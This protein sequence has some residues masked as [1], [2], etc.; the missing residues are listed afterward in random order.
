MNWKT[1]DNIALVVISFV[2]ITW[3]AMASSSVVS[4]LWN[5]SGPA[6]DAFVYPISSHGSISSYAI[7]ADLFGNQIVSA[8]PL[9]ETS[10]KLLLLGVM[11][12]EEKG[13]GLAILHTPSNQE[14][15]YHIGESPMEGVTL[16]AVFDDHVILERAGA[17][18]S[19]HFSQSNETTV[20][21][22]FIAA[23]Q[24]DSNLEAEVLPQN[25]RTD[26]SV[27]FKTV[28][29][30]SLG[31]RQDMLALDSDQVL[32][33]MG[34]S[35]KGNTFQLGAHSPLSQFGLQE[36]DQVI[37]VNGF[38]VETLRSDTALQAELRGSPSIQ[39]IIV[40]GGKRLQINFSLK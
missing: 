29:R 4:K 2:A 22:M 12:S 15:A 24:F 40:R 6:S 21:N 10:L 9:Q 17:S 37:S 5:R 14:G 31:N 26:E 18:E 27:M 28:N 7:S 32:E 16:Q 39:A 25:N 3:L 11:P 36:G 33:Q 8:K 35:K 23:S 34:I 30:D 19:L 1:L 38:D 20:S 13:Q